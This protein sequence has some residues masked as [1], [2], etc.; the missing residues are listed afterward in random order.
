MA[1]LVWRVKLVRSAGRGDDRGRG[2]THQRDEQ[3]GLSGLGL[4]LAEAKNSPPP[5]RRES[6]RHR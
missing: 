1:K 4:R 6:S 2:R 3:A 5:S